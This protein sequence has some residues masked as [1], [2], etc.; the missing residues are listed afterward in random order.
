MKAGWKM[1]KAPEK[2]NSKS[3]YVL[4]PATLGFL[5]GYFILHPAAMVIFRLL[6]GQHHS[7]GHGHLSGLV[8]EPIVHSFQLGMLPMGLAFGVVG[9]VVGLVYGNQNR[10]IKWQRDWL[11]RQLTQNKALVRELQNKADLL[12]KQNERLVELERMKRRTTHC[13]VHDFKTQL[14]CIEGFSNLLFENKDGRSGTDDHDALRRIRRQARGML[15]SINNLLDIARLEDAPTLRIESVH[16]VDLLA[17][18]AEDVAF[19]GREYR[20][21]IDPSAQSCPSVNGEPELIRRILMNL[22]SNAIKH[23]RS[24]TCVALGAEL[25]DGGNEVVFTCFDDGAG[26]PPD[27]LPTLF[28]PF[29]A[30]DPAPAESTGLGLAFARSAAEAH[31]GRVWCESRPEQGARFFVAIPF[32]RSRTMTDQQG[33]RKRLLVVEDDP[34][35]AAFMASI[36][37]GQGYNVSTAHDGEEAMSRVRESPPDAITLDI[38]MPKK[39][40]ALF[41]RQMKSQEALRTI[42]VIVVTGLTRNDPDWANIIHGL[43]DVEHLPQPEAYLEKPVEPETLAKLIKEVFEQQQPV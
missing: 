23:N 15:G 3:G 16:P 36:L 39:S 32:D 20:I 33:P 2:P 30:G 17:A 11:R 26:I 25:G 10:V 37:C 19:A 35:F 4:R 31:G 38:Q 43:L 18:V 8:W 22:V 21:V 27:R 40:G 41:Y 34:D 6:E 28:E 29:H 7:A 5:N 14:N 1:D 42:P 24:G 9:A 12:L 13:L